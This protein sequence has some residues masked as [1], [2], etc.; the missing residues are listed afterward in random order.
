MPAPEDLVTYLRLAPE[1]GGTRFGPFEGLEMRLG[2][3]PERCHIVLAEA[4]GV[5][6]EHAK[7]IRQR[8]NSL[9]VAPAE[10]TAS[11]FL[12]KPNERRPTQI[13]TP[14]AVRPGDAFS[15]VTQ[16]GP[17]FI[18]ELDVLPPE[19]IEK[20]EA[21]KR[22]RTGR[23]RL[24]AESLAAEGKR[25]V[26][27]RV[28]TLG[29][30]QMASRAWVFIKSGA[31]YNPRNIF[32]GVAIIGGYI[33]GGW[34]MCS[35]KKYQTQVTKVENAAQSCNQQLEIAKNL[36]AQGADFKFHEIV[37]QI[38]NSTLL[39]A[40]L[41]QDAAMRAEVKRQ[42]KIMFTNPKAWDWLVKPKGK[43][44]AA[45]FAKWRE[46]LYDDD[47]I[48]PD[49]AKLLMW[50][51]ATP[52]ELKSEFLDREDSLGAKV[53]GRGTLMSTYR[54]AKNLGLDAQPDTFIERDY[55]LVRDDKAKREELL[56]KTM[57]SW[58]PTAV[59][60]EGTLETAVDPVRQG[61]SGC[62]YLQGSDDRTEVGASV[63]MLA[64][65]V[66]K[67]GALLPDA[68]Q[69]WSPTAR[70]AKYWSADIPNM[71]LTQKK[72]GIDFTQTFTGTVLDQQGNGGKWV[73]ART[74]ETVARAIVVPCLA[75]LKGDTAEVAKILG[76]ENLPPPVSCLV[77]DWKLRNE[78]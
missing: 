56:L 74:A 45:E 4:L 19:V 6:P 49:T 69:P 63:R 15:L 70:V 75:V 10:R 57:Q 59:L 31:I 47:G 68:V 40:A 1:F 25:Q 39:G 22:V 54:Q 17:K 28:L 67:S 2:S 5:L 55:E 52:D 73:M 60:P 42:T 32:L 77:L 14:T 38:T 3:N 8:D 53:C 33:F 30:A 37:T 16:D 18:I 24:S 41:E 20:R 58:N 13:Q 61:R 51:G 26:W 66:G 48:D 72:I 64:K 44:K 34:A 43:Q 36:S 35:R 29:P 12:W 65:Q 46:R 11:I 50:L 78:E 27:W 21:E 23:R 76:D 9:I 62:L 71:D 7:V